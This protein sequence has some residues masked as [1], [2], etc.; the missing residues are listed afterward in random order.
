MGGNLWILSFLF[1]AGL[2]FEEQDNEGNTTAHYA[3]IGQRQNIVH[4]LFVMGVDFKAENSSGTTPI[5]L[6]ALNQDISMVSYLVELGCATGLYESDGN[7]LSFAVYH[8]LDVMALWLI[9]HKFPQVPRKSGAYPIHDAARQCSYEI[10]E[11]LLQ[12]G[13]DPNCRDNFGKTPLHFAAS[14]GKSEIVTLL[15]LKG[16]NPDALDNKGM[17]PICY[18]AKTDKP[19]VIEI[20]AR[21]GAST[22]IAQGAVSLILI[23]I[24]YKSQTNTKMSC[25]LVSC[26]R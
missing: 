23:R 16:A 3:A 14:R 5:K 25:A 18:A 9:Y 2:T 6:A 24:R 17:T 26:R 13:A 20:I 21:N 19:N 8:N 11:L 22:T 4:Y 10:C 15:L 7:L 1:Q 12:T